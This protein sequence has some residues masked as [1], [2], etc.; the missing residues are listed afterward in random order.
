MSDSSR[1]SQSGGNHRTMKPNVGTPKGVP[2]CPGKPDLCDPF[3]VSSLSRR[4][5]W[6]RSA[7]PPATIWQPF[8]LRD[9]RE[10]ALLKMSNSLPCFLS[11]VMP[12]LVRFRLTATMESCDRGAMSQKLRASE[13]G[14]ISRVTGNGKWKEQQCVALH[15][16]VASRRSGKKCENKGKVWRMWKMGADPFK[17]PSRN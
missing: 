6:Y 13:P 7:R 17:P 12:R 10:L 2:E 11:R 14:V 16:R 3:G 8:G 5:R 9:L 4:R 15:V 1:W